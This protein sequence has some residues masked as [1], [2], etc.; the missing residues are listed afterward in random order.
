MEETW[1]RITWIDGLP[2]DKYSISSYGRIRN[3]YTHTIRKNIIRPHGTV[4][5]LIST[6][7]Y[8]RHRHM[9]HYTLVA[10]NEWVIHKNITITIA[11][12]VAKAFLPPPDKSNPDIIVSIGY[13]DGNKQNVHAD[14]L[15][16]RYRI[17]YAARK[18]HK[19]RVNRKLTTE[20]VHYV[21]GMLLEEKGCLKKIR[22]RLPTE[23][24]NVT[25]EQVM[26][27]KYKSYYRDIS[28]EYF[29]YFDKTFIPL[30]N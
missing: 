29:D 24:P 21:C 22:K 7:P 11:T 25:I 10:D 13:K 8:R 5:C 9:V 6:A 30:I 12:H 15:E 23:L 20:D 17:S 28:D 19:P 18:A 4:M 14:N 26:A 27:I 16:Y 3:E 2:K 1:K